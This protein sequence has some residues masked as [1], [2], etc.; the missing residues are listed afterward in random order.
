MP[1]E[2]F[3]QFSQL[4]LSDLSLQEKLREVTDREEFIARVVQAGLERG[5][6]FSGEDVVEA[7]Q[8]RNR[9]WLER[10]I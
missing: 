4:V 7:M 1:L 3:E 10:W 9:A 8:A 2:K 6:E 5:F